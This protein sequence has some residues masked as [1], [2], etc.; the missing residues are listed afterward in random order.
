MTGSADPDLKDASAWVAENASRVK[1]RHEDP[2]V[3]AP[4]RRRK[5]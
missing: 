3:L 1:L 2:E 5:Y 4:S